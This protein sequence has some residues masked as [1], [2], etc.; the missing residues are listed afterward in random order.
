MEY[1]V[2]NGLFAAYLVYDGYRRKASNVWIWA[3]GT[4]LAGVL[5][6][7]FYFAG[8][9][10]RDGEVQTGGYGWNVLKNFVLLWTLLFLGLTF[11][12]CVMAETAAASALAG[13]LGL[14]VFGTIWFGVLVVALVFGLFIKKDV[15]R[16]GPTGPLTSDGE[17]AS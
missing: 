15:S 9:P 16:E 1:F 11:S 17:D 13:G 2:M 4:L 8:R 12:S 5:V 10:L 7:P 14:I 3:I 6:L